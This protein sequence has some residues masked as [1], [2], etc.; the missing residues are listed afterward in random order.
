MVTREPKLII[1]YYPRDSEGL[2]IHYT[3]KSADLKLVADYCNTSIKKAHNMDYFTF[4]EFLKD[5]IIYNN[6][7]T[8]EGREWLN[9]AWYLEQTKPDRALLR[10]EFGK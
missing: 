5:A 3:L 2:E 1:P 6:M 9:N 7:Q 8:K 10:K 4:M